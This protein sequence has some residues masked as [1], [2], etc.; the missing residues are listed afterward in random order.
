MMYNLRV[1]NFAP[2]SQL[3]SCTS[4]FSQQLWW[5]TKWPRVD[6]LPSTGLRE[7]P[8]L[9][10]Q[11]WPLAPIYLL[12]ECRQVWVFPG[13]WTSHIG[14]DSEFYLAVEQVTC[15]LLAGK[16]LWGAQGEISGAYPL[17]VWTL[18]GAQLKDTEEF[19]PS[20][21]MLGGGLAKRC[22]ENC[23]HSGKVLGSRAQ[24]GKNRGIPGPRLKDAEVTPL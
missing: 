13:F 7:G 17:M 20:Q 4:F 18:S 24:L 2:N 9:W 23:P 22:Q 10:Y 5:P 21:K 19:P 12:G 16:M 11:Q 15:P 8:E 3:S 14:W 6:L 1:V